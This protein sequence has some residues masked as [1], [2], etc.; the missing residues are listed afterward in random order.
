MEIEMGSGRIMGYVCLLFYEH[1]FKMSP[2]LTCFFCVSGSC[3]AVLFLGS[4]QNARN[5]IC[6]VSFF[7]FN[8]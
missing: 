2:F 4:D 6:R 5:L 7:N 1:V 8:Y 3:S